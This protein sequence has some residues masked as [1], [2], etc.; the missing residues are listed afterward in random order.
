LD[1][2]VDDRQRVSHQSD[3]VRGTTDERGAVAALAAANE[4]LAA[5]EA[6]A[7]YIERG[8]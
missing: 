6:W 1:A 8:Y 2:A 5:R 4:Q 7:K 3:A